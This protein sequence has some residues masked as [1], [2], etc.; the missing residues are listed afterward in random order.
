M[1]AF[2]LAKRLGLE[3]GIAQGYIDTYF[4]RYPH[5]KIYME[6]TSRRAQQLGYVETLAG[7]RIY[8]PNIKAKNFMLRSAAERAAINAP[9]QGTAAD[10]IKMAMINID[11]WLR[12]NKTSAKMVMQVHDELVFEC[13][14]NEVDSIMQT[15]RKHMEN[16]VQLDVPLLV[17]IGSGDNWDAAH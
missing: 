3:R 7:R 4:A 17:S 6:E 13:V 5:V 11:V 8:I 2:G 14:E 1:S 12:S 9:I 15:I 16:V 10:I